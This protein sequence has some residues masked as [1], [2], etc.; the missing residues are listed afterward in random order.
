MILGSQKLGLAIHGQ[1]HLLTG[2]PWTQWAVEPPSLIGGAPFIELQSH[3][4]SPLTKSKSLGRTKLRVLSS[5]TPT[6]LLKSIC[7]ERRLHSPTHFSFWKPPS[8]RA[9]ELGGLLDTLESNMLFPE[10]TSKGKKIKSKVAS[11]SGLKQ[12]PR[13]YGLA[14]PGPNSVW[15]YE[16]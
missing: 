1:R 11:C 14:P 16:Q 13:C 10:L 7:K 4:L 9:S 15:S 3:S 12:K 8:C 5:D 2:I 6:R